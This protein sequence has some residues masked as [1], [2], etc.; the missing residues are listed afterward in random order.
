MSGEACVQKIWTVLKHVSGVTAQAITVGEA[1]IACTYPAAYP[2]AC[3][4]I[5]SIGFRANDPEAAVRINAGDS[6]RAVESA[7][8]GVAKAPA[9]SAASCTDTKT[10]SPTAR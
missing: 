6:P 9:V 2:S 7:G 4:A 8:T 10:T 1:T 5:N 3:S